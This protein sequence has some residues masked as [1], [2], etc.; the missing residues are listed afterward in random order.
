MEQQRALERLNHIRRGSDR[1]ESIGSAFNSS[2]SPLCSQKKADCHIDV[3]LTLPK[4]DIIS[5]WIFLAIRNHTPKIL[6][7]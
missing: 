7:R 2:G 4:I 6:C 5:G 3:T 1:R